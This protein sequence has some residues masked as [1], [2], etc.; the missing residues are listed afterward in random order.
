MATSADRLSSDTS[1]AGPATASKAIEKALDDSQ[2]TGEI[3]LSG[4]MLK[5]FPETAFNYDIV[6][7]TAAG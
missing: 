1:L 6:D 4:R 7:T 2:H 5:D 3:N